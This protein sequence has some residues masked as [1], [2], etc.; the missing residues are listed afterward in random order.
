MQHLL[1]GILSLKARNLIITQCEE[2]YNTNYWSCLFLFNSTIWIVRIEKE[3]RRET[4]EAG[5]FNAG[6]SWYVSDILKSHAVRQK[7][8]PK[9][10]RASSLF[11]C[12]FAVSRLCFGVVEP[13][14][15]G[16]PKRR[17]RSCVNSASRDRNN[18]VTW[19]SFRT[20]KCET[21]TRFPNVGECRLLSNKKIRSKQ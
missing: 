18:D 3:T 19:N 16:E 17:P 14:A 6:K 4:V 20:P 7:Y 12:G 21:K 15:I 5:L 10:C 2:E 13:A 11:S 9:K 1:S 8:Y